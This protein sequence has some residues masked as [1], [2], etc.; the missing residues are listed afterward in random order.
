MAASFQVLQPRNLTWYASGIDRQRLPATHFPPGPPMTRL[1][2]G[3]VF[4][5]IFTLTASASAQVVPEV[6]YVFPPGGPAG[7]TVAV[8]LGGSEWTPDMQF[9]VHDSRVKLEV[10]GPPGELFIPPPPYWFGAKGRLSSPPLLR[11][12]PARFVLPVGLPPG[13]V[14]WQAANANGVTSTGVFVVGA[15]PELVEDETRKGPQSLPALPV[16]VSG[17]LL[18]NEEV[19]RYRFV[20]PKAGPVTCEL[21]ARRLGLKF[22]GVI[23]VFDARNRRVAEA[24]DTEGDDPRLTFPAAAGG[25][26]QSRRPAN[27]ASPARSSSSVSGCSPA[28]P[29]SN[30]SARR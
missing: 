17:R 3:I 27:A 6:G 28:D 4:A 14:R 26:R 1:P 7:S 9:F 25:S 13:P 15:G 30:P 12:R 23:E 5:A 8:H 22:N 16:T 11:E 21:T 24:V 10:L 2:A 29:S 18:K 19:D 20:V